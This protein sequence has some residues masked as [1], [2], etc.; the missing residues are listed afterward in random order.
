MKRLL[1]ALAMLLPLPAAGH[2][3]YLDGLQIIHPAIPATPMDST[4]AHIYMAIVNDGTEPERLLGIETAFGPAVIERA[5]TDA[6]GRTRYERMA[7]IDIPVGE[8]V[9]MIQGE[10]RARVDNVTQP[11]FEGGELNGAFVFEKRGRFEMFYMIDP[12][13]ALVDETAATVEPQVD[14]AAETIAIAEAVR[15]A[16]GAQAMVSPIALAGDV[17]IVGWIEGDEAA[18]TFVRKRDGQWQVVMWSGPSLLLPSTMNSLGVNTATADL[19]RRELSAGETALGPAISTLFD[20]Y[21]GTV[22][23]P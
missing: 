17:A 22:T 7:W 2:E 11:L 10:M 3:F 9:L 14:R 4:T 16:V 20:A 18:R 5:V 13:E 21:P 19:L 1:F 15:N 12:L 8:T 6:D 23:L